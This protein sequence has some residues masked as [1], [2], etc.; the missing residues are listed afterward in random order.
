MGLEENPGV[1]DCYILQLECPNHSIN[2]DTL[3]YF[4][5]SPNNTANDLPEAFCTC[6][7][8]LKA[9]AGNSTFAIV[10]FKASL[11]LPTSGC[12]PKLQT[13]ELDAKFCALIKC[14]TSCTKSK[15]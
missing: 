2:T 13:P 7:D 6:F 14:T 5:L 10:R 12:L 8:A 15:P 4:Q 9:Q 1:Q 11:C 3:Q